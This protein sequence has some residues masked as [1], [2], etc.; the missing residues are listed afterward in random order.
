M[1]GMEYQGLRWFVHMEKAELEETAEKQ[2]WNGKLKIPKC[3]LFFTHLF[4]WRNLSFVDFP[5]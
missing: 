2:P 5:V 4:A 1:F 3:Q